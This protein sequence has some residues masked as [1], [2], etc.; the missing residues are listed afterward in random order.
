M[1]AS[2]IIFLLL[3]LLV[4]LLFKLR[5]LSISLTALLLFTIFLFGSGILTQW[6][7]TQLQFG[8][9]PDINWKA[10]NLLIVLG[11]GTTRMPYSEDLVTSLPGVSRVLK[12]ARLYFDCKTKKMICK[13]LASGGDPRKNG[14]SEAAVMAKELLDMKI[15]VEDILLEDKSNNT[16]LNAKFTKEYLRERDPF[17]GIYLITSGTHLKRS[18]LYFEHFGIRATGIPSD[19]LQADFSLIPKSSNVYLLD[20]A[21]HEYIGIL[22][23]H[24]YNFMEWN[25]PKVISE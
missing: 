23:Y 3:V 10:R 2:I 9:R 18:L 19:H 6:T 16:F 12:V 4:A 24:F 11:S 22:R 17:E 1:L 7:L 8:P 14:L 21:L 25:E 13:I 5:G 15:P 20:M